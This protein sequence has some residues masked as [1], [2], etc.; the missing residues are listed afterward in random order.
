M[1]TLEADYGW[2]Y[3]DAWGVSPVTTFNFNCL[4]GPRY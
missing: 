4:S 3:D 2:M 1:L